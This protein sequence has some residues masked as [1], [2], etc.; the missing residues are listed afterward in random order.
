MLRR[1]STMRKSVHREYEYKHSYD[2]GEFDSPAGKKF[3]KKIS[4]KRIRKMFN[5]KGKE[6]IEETY[7]E[8]NK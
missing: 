6:S 3:T 7:V 1:Y 2:F 4:N 5:N 8:E